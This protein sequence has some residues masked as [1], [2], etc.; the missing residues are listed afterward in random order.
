MAL[1]T[2][3]PAQSKMSAMRVSQRTHHPALPPH[4]KVVDY[5]TNRNRVVEA[6]RQMVTRWQQLAPHDLSRFFP[7]TLLGQSSP[8]NNDWELRYYSFLIPS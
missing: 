1:Q 4:D 2:R 7:L 8:Q 6:G 5:R 3:Y